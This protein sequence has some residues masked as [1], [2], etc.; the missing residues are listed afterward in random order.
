MGS[1]PR[2]KVES[3]P[4]GEVPEALTEFLPEITSPGADVRI[5]FENL[6]EKPELSFAAPRAGLRVELFDGDR[7]YIGIA[8]SQVEEPVQSRPLPQSRKHCLR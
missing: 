4:T 6:V 2:K 7:R 8:R 1:V 3:P 5:H